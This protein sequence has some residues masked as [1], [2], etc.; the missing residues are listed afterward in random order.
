MHSTSIW[1]KLSLRDLKTVY[2]IVLVFFVVCVRRISVVGVDIVPM[3][4]YQLL[5]FH[6]VS[7]LSLNSSPE[8]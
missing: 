3:S 8:F 1:S 7:L 6:I 5:P 4:P 2:Y